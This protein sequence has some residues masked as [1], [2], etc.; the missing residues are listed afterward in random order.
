MIGY[1]QDGSARHWHKEINRWIDELAKDMTAD[2]CNWNDGEKLDLIEEN[3][4]KGS[5][6]CRSRHGRIGARSSNEIAIYHLWVLMNFE[7]KQKE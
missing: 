6:Q 5:A 2:D 3:T 1:V 4:K 7:Q